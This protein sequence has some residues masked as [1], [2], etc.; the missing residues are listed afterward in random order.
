MKGGGE[1]FDHPQHVEQANDRR[2]GLTFAAAPL[3]KGEDGHPEIIGGAG[4][5]EA[6]AGDCFAD[7]GGEAIGGGVRAGAAGFF[8]VVHGFSLSRIRK[9]RH[10]G[11]FGVSR[12]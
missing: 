11:G 6:Q 5:V 8:G 7:P 1:C 2:A 10:G 12:G 9:T 3:A 4:F